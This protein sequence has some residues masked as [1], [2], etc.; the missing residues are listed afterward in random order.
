M[1]VA[2]H[3]PGEDLD[4]SHDWSA[5][6]DAQ[7]SPSDT[8]AS[9]SWVLTGP[10]DGGSPSPSAHDASTTGN[11]VSVF[12]NNLQVGGVYELRNVMATAAGR[13]FEHAWTI[14]CGYR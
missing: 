10:D 14:R 13:Q 8:I 1:T 12:V 4:Y 7:G 11:T 5:D 2:Y 3:G 6:L 9:S